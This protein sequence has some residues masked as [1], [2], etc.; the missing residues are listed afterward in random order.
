MLAK[1]CRTCQV[2]AKQICGFGKC[3]MSLLWCFARIACQIAKFFG[4]I[5]LY[6]F[7]YVYFFPY[8]N[9]VFFWQIGKQY[10]LDIINA[11]FHSCRMCETFGKNN[12]KKY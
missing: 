6:I 8:R 11:L 12:I 10:N 7:L 1:T 5:S 3:E 2:L 9:R 4:S